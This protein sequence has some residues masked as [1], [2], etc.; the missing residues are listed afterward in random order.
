[1]TSKLG[2]AKAATWSAKAPMTSVG[3]AAGRSARRFSVKVA[4]TLSGSVPLP[5]TETHQTP[6]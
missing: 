5:A 2:S 6:P 3:G 4:I 1:M